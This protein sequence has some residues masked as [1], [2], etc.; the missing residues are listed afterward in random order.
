[1]WLSSPTGHLDGRLEADLREVGRKKLADAVAYLKKNAG[2]E[3][4]KELVVVR[5]GRI[6]WH[7]D[8]VDKVHGIWSCT[9]LFTPPSCPC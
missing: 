1:M 2:R 8:D 5:R 9:K 6:V 3:G 7:G 4:V